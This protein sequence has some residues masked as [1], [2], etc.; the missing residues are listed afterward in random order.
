M[1]LAEQLTLTSEQPPMT[2][3]TSTPRKGV[4]ME[5][6]K[7]PT[8]SGKTIDYPEFKRGWQKVAGGC[9]DDANQV[10]QIKFKVNT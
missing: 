4:E 1:Q 8:F 9:W 7:A 10:E 3:V 6:S 5:K 2:P